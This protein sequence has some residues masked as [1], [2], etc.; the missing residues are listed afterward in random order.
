MIGIFLGLILAI[1]RLPILPFAIGLY[2][3]LDL[4]TTIMLGGLVHALIKKLG[5]ASQKGVL[6]ASGLVAGDACMGVLIALLSILGLL[7]NNQISIINET[8]SFFTLLGVA[9]ILGL[10]AYRK[11]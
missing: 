11:K 3:P 6:A 7:P 2:L 10:M 9:L 5:S 4:S 1:L 8:G